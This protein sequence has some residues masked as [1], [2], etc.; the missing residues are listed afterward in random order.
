MCIDGYLS[1]IARALRVTGDGEGVCG[2]VCVLGMGFESRSRAL[3]FLHVYIHVP[4]FLINRETTGYI[5]RCRLIACCEWQ[6][7]KKS[8]GE[9][10]LLPACM[11]ACYLSCLFSSC[12][13]AVERK[14]G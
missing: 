6:R 10:E 14:S 5:G 8:Y 13:A 12:K 2:G 9:E 7:R 3:L 11:H 1:K 4:P